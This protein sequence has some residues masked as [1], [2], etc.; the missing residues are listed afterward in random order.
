M[1]IKQFQQKLSKGLPSS[2]YLLYSSED[3]L[4]Y[5]ALSMIKERNQDINVFNF[6]VFDMSSSD[7]SL[8]M[9]EIVDILNTLPFMSSR[10]TVVIKNVQKLSKKDM[11][12]LENYM[13]SP[14]PSSLLI[15]L[16]ERTS[17][18]LFEMSGLKNIKVISL[19]INEKDIP[20]WIKDRS[21]KKGIELTDR[22][23]EYLISFIG[24]DL[25]M[26]YAE[27]EKLSSWETGRIFDV[28]D[29]KGVVYAGVEYSAFDLVNALMNKDTKKVFRIFENVNRTIKPEM[30]LGALNYQFT[31]LRSKAFK[32]GS[33][34]EKE[35][36]REIFVLLHK[37]DAAV[38]TS[39]NYVIEDLLFKLLRT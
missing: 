26:L 14:S 20:L 38:K 31:S 12:N 16:Y 3:F 15:M 37:A 32:G 24:T 22:A 10:K 17:P 35:R 6:E 7:D 36:F 33:D 39:H 9:E 29:I 27:I 21:K 18:K 1:S 28:D 23:V 4:L 11:K 25:G 30:L 5:E 19:N 34:R 8:P 2:V 13:A